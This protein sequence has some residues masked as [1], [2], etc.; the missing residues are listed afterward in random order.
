MALDRISEGVQ[1]QSFRFSLT[2]NV[3]AMY[4]CRLRGVHQDSDLHLN[5]RRISCVQETWI[6]CLIFNTRLT[7][8]PHIRHFN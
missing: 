6:L 3:E 7:W 5:G 8:V 2:K 4:L 1:T